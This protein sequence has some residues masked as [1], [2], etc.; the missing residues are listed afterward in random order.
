MESEHFD[1][2]KDSNEFFISNMCKSNYFA[3][4]SL[5]FKHYSKHKNIIE[6]SYKMKGNGNPLL[7]IV[8]QHHCNLE[9]LDLVLFKLIDEIKINV[10]ILN[11]CYYICKYDKKNDVFANMI[12]KYGKDTNQEI[13]AKAAMTKFETNAKNKVSNN[14]GGFKFNLMGASMI[15]PVANVP[16]SNWKAPTSMF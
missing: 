15:S 3:Y 9:W 6:N 5:I 7:C 14:S 13:D 10:E 16:V 12:I 11:E 4:C 1:G 2:I 8:K